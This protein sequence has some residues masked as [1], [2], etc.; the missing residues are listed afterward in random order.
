MQKR[1]NE[2][3]DLNSLKGHFGGVSYRYLG[4]Y[5]FEAND[6][7]SPVTLTPQIALREKAEL[8]AQTVGCGSPYIHRPDLISHHLISF[9]SSMSSIVCTEWSFRHV[10][11]NRQQFMK[12][13]WASECRQCT[14]HFS[15]GWRDSNEFLRTM[16]D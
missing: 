4:T 6:S 15:T 9:S 12:F 7:P 11:K 16:A 10:K 13:R 2:C 3:A 5:R 8:V 14:A 1:A